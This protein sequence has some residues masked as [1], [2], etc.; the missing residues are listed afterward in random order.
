M[1]EHHG[2]SLH[3]RPTRDY[4]YTATL[5]MPRWVVGFG[6]RRCTS[7]YRP[8]ARPGCTIGRIE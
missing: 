4:A 6:T 8:A 2:Q 5:I 1:T 3:N 7:R